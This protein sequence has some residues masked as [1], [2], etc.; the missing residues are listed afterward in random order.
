MRGYLLPLEQQG[1]I[2]VEEEFQQACFHM[3]VYTRYVPTPSTSPKRSQP[4][5]SATNILATSLQ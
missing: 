5:A 2:D 3:S 1:K 4:A